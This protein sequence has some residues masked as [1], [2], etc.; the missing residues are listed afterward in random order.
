[1]SALVV[2]FVFYVVLATAAKCDINLKQVPSH[3]KEIS[4]TFLRLTAL[5]EDEGLW[6]ARFGTYE[7]R[8]GA[9]LFPCLVNGIF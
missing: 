4:T 3:H 9:S 7:V 1:M 8:K 5:R 6:I 2:S